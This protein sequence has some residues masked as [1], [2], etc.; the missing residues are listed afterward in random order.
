MTYLWGQP[1]NKNVFGYCC[2]VKISV[3][4]YNMGDSIAVQGAWLY[5]RH[6]VYI[7]IME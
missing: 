2:I 4:K 5:N 1:A 7:G 6:F 3:V